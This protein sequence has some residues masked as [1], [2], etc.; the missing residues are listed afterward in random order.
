MKTYLI[1][2]KLPSVAKAYTLVELTVAMLVGILVAVISLTLFNTQLTSFQIIR[3]Q[4]FLIREAPQINNSLN[5]IIPRANFF[6]LYPTLQ[7]AV[8]ETNS[9]INN[10]P[11]MVLQ[12][13]N[14]TTNAAGNAGDPNATVNFGV[15]AFNANTNSLDYYN[16]GNNLANLNLAAPDWTI[17]SQAAD[18]TF[19]VESGVL[20]TQITGPNGSQI[21]HSTTT[22]R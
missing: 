10:A 20:R 19:F 1:K 7:N 11:V 2:N 8:A 21:T 18:V 17:S 3:T 16:P 6:R 12:F 22:Q 5:Q 9:T 13:Q 4:D 14:S 15:I